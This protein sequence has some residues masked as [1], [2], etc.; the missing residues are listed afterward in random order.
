MM[1][2]FWP[3]PP[4]LP[5]FIKLSK[6]WRGQANRAVRAW[7]CPA[8]PLDISHARPYLGRMIQF[9]HTFARDVPLG[10]LEQTPEAAPAPALVVLNDGLAQDLGLV[11]EILRAD[12]A[13][14]FSGAACPATAI[15][16]A[17]AYAGHQFG[18]FSP[19]LGDGRAHLLGEIITPQ[20]A[21]FD[22]HLKGS[23][24]TAFSRGGDG[25]AHLAPMLREYLISEFM[26]AVHIPTTRALAVV[27]TGT[28]VLRDN[29][30]RQGAVLARI[31]ASHIRVGTFEYFVNRGD[32]GSLRALMAHTLARHYPSAPR[33]A[34]GLLDAVI[35]AQAQLIAQWMGAGFVHGVMNTDN[36]ALSGETIDYGPCAFLDGYDEGAVFSSIDHSGRYAF[37]MQPRI[38]AWNISRLAQALLPLMPGDEA[39][40]VDAANARLDGIAGIYRHAWRGVFGRKLGLE[41]PNPADD[42]LIEGFLSLIQ[43]AD[44][45]QCFRALQ[46]A[47]TD[48]A[49]LLSLM[50]LDKR[51]AAGAWLAQWRAR[52]GDGDLRLQNPA[53]IPRNHL[54]QSALDAAEAGDMAPFHALLAHLQ[55]PFA[56]AKTREAY[57]LGPPA[58]FGRYTTYCGT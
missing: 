8:A 11:P 16:R 39:A 32:I 58:G 25:R 49:R 15:P 9:E 27:T 31:A 28:Q 50:V 14:W 17:M 23:G 6:T 24:R 2:A 46:A 21:R 45:T 30:L 34:F 22:L 40:A 3:I 43:G 33:T 10:V 1:G 52:V 54:V 57:A 36:M 44:F 20:G 56:S 29:A 7:L 35:A 42:D 38:L 18:G 41:G 51:S 53:I 19:V 26:A 48:A 5:L 13:A 47:K 37:A 4:H 55:T 12:G